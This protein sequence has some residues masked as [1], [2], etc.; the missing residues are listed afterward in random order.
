MSSAR[1]RLA[2]P[3]LIVPLKT[4]LRRRMGLRITFVLPH[5]SLSG[6]DK[7]TFTFADGLAER[8]HEVTV[9]HGALPTLKGRIRDR[10]FGGRGDFHRPGPKVR[11]IG[12]KGRP[13]DLPAF[14]PDADVLIGSWW[15]TVDAISKAPATKGRLIHHV[16]DH[17]VFDY[18]P[19]RSAD[20]YRLLI[21]KIV[22]SSWLL[23]VMRQ[24]YQAADVQ[25]VANPVDLEHFTCESRPIAPA[26]RVGT[27]YAAAPRKNSRLAFDA[28]ELGRREI[29][30]LRL[31]SF[32]ADLPPPDLRRRGYVDFHLRPDQHAIPDLYRSCDYWLFASR[33]E[34]FGL[35]ILEAM[36]SGTPVIATPAGAAPDLVNEDNGAIVGHD[37]REMARAI[38]K[39][40]SAGEAERLAMS[41]AARATAE[42]HDIASAVSRFEAIL[43]SYGG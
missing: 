37:A 23:D 2:G 19:A 27:V 4:Y 43:L 36:A 38:V 31:V 24:T 14:L 33:S 20:V 39:L 1:T 22:V 30:G 6:G 26:A 25:L 16:Q 40:H 35:P 12:A 21:P 9:V 18:L 29:P 28:V 15:E 32:G 11:L 3:P 42:A 34:G 13:A 8:G 17:E 5:L 10:L 41:G 7:I